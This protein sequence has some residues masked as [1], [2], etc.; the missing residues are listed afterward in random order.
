MWQWAKITF[1]LHVSIEWLLRSLFIQRHGSNGGCVRGD[2]YRD[3]IL[4]REVTEKS[5][6]YIPACIQK[7]KN[8]F[9]FLFWFLVY[10]K[11][12]SVYNW[13]FIKLVHTKYYFS[14]LLSTKLVLQ[15]NICTFVCNL[16]LCSFEQNPVTYV[17]NL[18]IILYL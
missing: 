7:N 11:I 4:L 18:R 8:I 13:N 2:T 16:Q 5:R 17:K 1:F 9:A 3:G 15:K 14:I 12:V 10:D 6:L